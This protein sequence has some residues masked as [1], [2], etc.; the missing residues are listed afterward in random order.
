MNTPT[1]KYNK[2]PDFDKIAP[3]IKD[4]LRKQDELNYADVERRIKEGTMGVVEIGDY[5]VAIVQFM[6]Y[7]NLNAI[8]I[9]AISG[10]RMMEW[11]PSF[12]RYMIAW[13]KEY[14]VD[15]IEAMGRP[16]WER[17]LDH[18]GAVKKYSFMTLEV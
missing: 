15:R 16:G 14:G 6:Q 11:L 17:V 3:F 7:P 18:Y 2:D 1:I 9:F 12:A 5:A 13:G 4:A 10:T 8:R